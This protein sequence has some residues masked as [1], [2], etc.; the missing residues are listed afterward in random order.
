ML[1][2]NCELCLAQ[3]LLMN[4][5]HNLLILQQTLCERNSDMAGILKK[6]G[7][8]KTCDSDEDIPSDDEDN[9]AR[10]NEGGNE[11]Y[12]EAS[13][14]KDDD[15]KDSLKLPRKRKHAMVGNLI[16]TR[17]RF[18]VGKSWVC[19]SDCKDSLS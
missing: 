13:D 19:C 15:E 8:G 2:S 12:N 3:Q 16:D 18:M 1:M 17:I 5:I 14:E 10:D 11:E 9:E 6:G 4:L 7:E